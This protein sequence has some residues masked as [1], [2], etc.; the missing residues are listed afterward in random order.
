MDDHQRLKM[1]LLRARFVEA[2]T[3]WNWSPRSVVS[4]EQNVRYFFDWLER[5]TEI[6][7]LARVTAETMVSYQTALLAVERPDGRRLS[8]GTQRHRLG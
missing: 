3:A 7:D 5:E 4:Y 2:M 1:D 8:V 6:E